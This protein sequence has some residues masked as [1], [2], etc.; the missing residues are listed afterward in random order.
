MIPDPV[1]GREAE[2]E[3][4]LADIAMW[5]EYGYQDLNSGGV[6]SCVKKRAKEALAANQEDVCPEHGPLPPGLQA[7][8]R[9]ERAP[10][11]AHSSGS[12]AQNQEDEW[13]YT[14]EKPHPNDPMLRRSPQCEDHET[15]ERLKAELQAL[16]DWFNDAP[17]LRAERLL[18]DLHRASEQPDYGEITGHHPEGPDQIVPPQGED[19]EENGRLLEL[20]QKTVQLLEAIDAGLE[21]EKKLWP[22]EAIKA[23]F[24]KP[25]EE[26]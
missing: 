23:A 19:H 3:A 11:P 24:M 12:A 9:C 10:V 21:D 22:A 18:Y 6:L 20:R 14:E 4:A 1:G 25:E 16:V 15:I 7:C 13:Q 2:I 5:A 17:F 8:D 26:A